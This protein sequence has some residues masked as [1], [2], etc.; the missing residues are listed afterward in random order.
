MRD[1]TGAPYETVHKSHKYYWPILTQADELGYII[2]AEPER[3]KQDVLQSIG[4]DSRFHYVVTQVCEA[5]NPQGTQYLLQIRNPWTASDSNSDT[6]RSTQAYNSN[7]S[8]ASSDSRTVWLKLEDFN[9]LFSKVSISKI[10]DAYC[11]N[12]IIL[13]HVKDAFSAVEFK[14]ST[15]MHGFLE[16]THNDRRFY[17]ADANYRYPDLDMVFAKQENNGSYS[18]VGRQK[19]Q[20]LKSN[21]IEVNLTEGSYI[22]LVSADWDQEIHDLKVSFYGN[23]AINLKRLNF[24]DCPDLLEN[25]L[26]NPA[27]YE[28]DSINSNNSSLANYE[29]NGTESFANESYNNIN[30]S[31]CIKSIDS[32]AI[33]KITPRDVPSVENFFSPAGSMDLR[34]RAQQANF[35]LGRRSGR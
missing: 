12:N 16:V 15:P 5:A 9:D 10:H 27:I 28:E 24:K 6:S 1:L 18:H 21:C 25:I 23:G 26:E 35:F 4:L 13:R 30:V 29:S 17:Q 2:M 19:S 33:Q 31:K 20:N 3:E 11:Y 22:L 8:E 7:N 32:L 14:V 34:N